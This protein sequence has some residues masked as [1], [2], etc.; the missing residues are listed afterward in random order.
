MWVATVARPV[1]RGGPSRLA[2]SSSDRFNENWPCQESPWTSAPNDAGKDYD[3]NQFSR[4]RPGM[5]RKCCSLSVTTLRPWTSADEDRYPEAPWAGALR[6]GARE[7][8]GSVERQS[9]DL[10]DLPG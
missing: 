6:A 9:L 5:R 8:V 7:E 10:V 3:L 1:S 2:I 4:T